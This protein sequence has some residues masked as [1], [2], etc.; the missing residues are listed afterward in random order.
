MIDTIETFFKNHAFNVFIILAISYIAHKFL[1]SFVKNVIRRS[2]RRDDFKTDRDE[3]LR[4]DTLISTVGAGLRVAVWIMTGLLVLGEIGIDIGPLLAGAG[5]A[6]VALGFGAQTMVRDFLAGMFILLEN[7]YRVGDVI[8]INNEISGSV[9]NITLRQTSLRD[10]DGM[11]HHVPNGEIRVATNMTMTFAN[12]N[13]DVGVGYDTDIEKLE[14]LVNKIGSKMSEEEPWNKL[15]IE[16]PK[17][18]RVKD[19]GDSAVIIKIIGKTQ[20][21][22]QWQVTGELRKRLLIEFRKAKIEIPFPQRVI[23]EARKPALAKSK[24]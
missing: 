10:L 17:F 14:L 2:V 5:I 20:P 11:L 15:I 19:F 21:M 4:E 24:K 12:V 1:H 7:Q 6:G 9:E 3:K 8:K 23:H 18:L 22:K 13:L 16:A